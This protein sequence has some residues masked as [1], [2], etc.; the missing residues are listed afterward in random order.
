MRA[1]TPARTALGV[2]DQQPLSVGGCEHGRPGAPRAT[3]AE[4]VEATCTVPWLFAPVTI[5]GHEY[6]DGG[7]WSPTNLDAAPASRDTHVLCLN[8][9][10]G[11]TG[12]H[13]LVGVARRVARS[14]VSIEALALRRRGAEVQTIGPNGQSEA[15]MGHDFMAREP[16][17]RVLAAGYNQGL[18]L[19]ERSS[20]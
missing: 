15:A 2:A 5:A 7:V 16:R 8:P 18:A 11:I 14:T 13:T 20:L 17:D 9:T 1:T 12:A 10:G 6:V 3:V 19:G 4:A